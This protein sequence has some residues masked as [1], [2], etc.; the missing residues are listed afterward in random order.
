MRV[1]NKTWN[2]AW[3]RAKTHTCQ[4][5][6]WNGLSHVAWQL[7]GW[8]LNCPPSQGV[9]LLC[10]TALAQP[11]RAHPQGTSWAPTTL[12]S[13]QWLWTWARL[14]TPVPKESEASIAVF[15]GCRDTWGRYQEVTW[16]N[17]ITSSQGRMS[18][19]HRLWHTP[20]GPCRTF[21][22]E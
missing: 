12:K 18:V 9:S 21:K 13:R 4:L 5:C 8:G 17:H 20:F 3:N 19:M 16:V 22:T 1:K 10:I 6:S 7:L 14:L 2:S 11:M 15:R